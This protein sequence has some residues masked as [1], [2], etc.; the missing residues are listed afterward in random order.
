[1]TPEPMLVA[2]AIAVR[3]DFA[4]EKRPNNGGKFAKRKTLTVV[5]GARSNEPAADAPQQTR[6]RSTIAFPYGDL[7]DAVIVAR[8]VYKYAGMECSPDQLAGWMHQTTSSGG[9]R[10]RLS[11]SRIFGLIETEQGKIKLTSLGRQVVDR[12]QEH[13]A[14]AKAFLTVPLYN[15]VY[16]KYRERLLPPRAALQ[17]EMAGLGVSSKQ[18]D[19]ARQAFERSAQ[20]AN[21]F[22]QGNDRLIMPT[23][24]HPSETV[25]IKAGEDRG[26]RVVSGG[27]GNGPTWHPF[28]QGLIQTLPKADSEWPASDRVKWLKTAANVFDLIYKGEGSIKGEAVVKDRKLGRSRAA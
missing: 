1:M 15:A 16:E 21:F 10:T 5:N 9:F 24:A 14:R 19:R 2:E 8:T 4:N 22:A 23:G 20:Q 18:T 3:A 13:E 6:E 25:P 27:G 12:E 7:D 26:E 17:H 28:I 11:T